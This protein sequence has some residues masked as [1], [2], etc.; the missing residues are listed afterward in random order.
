MAQASKRL[1][2]DSDWLIGV[3]MGGGDLL[4]PVEQLASWRE[5]P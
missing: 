1:E 2:K 4:P 3:W 5:G